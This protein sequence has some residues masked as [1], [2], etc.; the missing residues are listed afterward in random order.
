MLVDWTLYNIIGHSSI[1]NKQIR[2]ALVNPNS[3]LCISLQHFTQLCLISR[4][5]LNTFQI[6][7]LF[8]NQDCEIRWY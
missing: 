3:Q 8:D 5:V 4:L 6:V 1:L 2:K 7:H